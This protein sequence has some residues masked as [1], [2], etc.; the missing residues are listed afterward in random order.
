MD[1]REGNWV[2]DK[3]SGITQVDLFYLQRIIGNELS[4]F[5]PIRLNRNILITNG[6]VET[7]K[8][9]WIFYIKECI[10]DPASPYSTTKKKTMPITILLYKPNEQYENSYY[11]GLVNQPI[12]LHNLQNLHEDVTGVKMNI[13]KEDIV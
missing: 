1:I 11:L 3:N 12:F 13:S 6:F 7:D 10:I 5:E 4:S 2:K 9:D 8:G